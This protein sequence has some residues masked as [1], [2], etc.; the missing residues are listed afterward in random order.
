MID[1]AR[2]F[3]TLKRNQDIIKVFEDLAKIKDKDT[4]SQLSAI[5][6]KGTI[7]ALL[8]L[9]EPTG[10]AKRTAQAVSTGLLA[11]NPTPFVQAV[12]SSGVR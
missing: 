6:E 3:G 12:T 10:F 4:K 2:E 5:I 1:Y 9:G 7:E 11:A 8:S